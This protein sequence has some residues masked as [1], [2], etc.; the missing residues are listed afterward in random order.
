MLLDP[1]S[2]QLL[3][4]QRMR[5]AWRAAE[6]ARLA[7]TARGP[8]QPRGRRILKRVCMPGG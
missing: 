6:R 8:R 1:F 4:E 2:V 5:D 3:A 7:Q